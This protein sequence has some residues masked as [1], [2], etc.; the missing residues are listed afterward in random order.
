MLVVPGGAYT[1][2]QYEK[3]GTTVYIADPNYW[4][5]NRTPR[6]SRSPTTRTPTR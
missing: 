6:R 2:K 1:L 4:G 5:P 3:K